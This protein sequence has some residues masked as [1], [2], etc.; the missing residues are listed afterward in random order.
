[1]PQDNTR[2]RRLLELLLLLLAQ[3]YRYTRRE[4]EARYGVSEDTV[5]RD[6]A[7]LRDAGLRVEQDGAY[8]FAVLP[9]GQTRTLKHLQAL[10]DEERQTLMRAAEGAF[11]KTGHAAVVRRKLESLYDFQRLGLRALRSPELAK[12]DALERAIAG[13]TCV[14]LVDYRSTNSG[15]TSDRLAEV[16][17]LD[18]ANGVAHAYDLARRAL[19][20]F[21]LDRMDRVEVLDGE[22]WRHADA[23]VVEATDAF[24]IV[25]RRQVR[26]HLRLG[27]AAYNDLLERFPGARAYTEPGAEVDT[28]D[29]DARVNAGFLGVSGFVLG[30][31]GDVEVLEPAG[32]LEEVRGRAGRLFSDSSPPPAIPAG[33]SG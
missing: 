13:E 10:T 31:A 12:I 25:S 18:T 33:G 26:V 7:I 3:P 4:L 5:R 15:K 20:H 22:P 24:R 27:V 21:R 29:F 23:H 8:R 14:R 11:A 17:H 32:L 16:F 9:E 30:N 28:Y 1:M 2:S 6:V 19:R